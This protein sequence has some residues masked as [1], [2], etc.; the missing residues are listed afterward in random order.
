[1][2]STSNSSTNETNIDAIVITLV[3]LMG[4]LVL[5]P[6]Y[7]KNKTAIE[8]KIKR[9]INKKSH[10]VVI[11]TYGPSVAG[12]PFY[13]AHIA[14][15]IKF[16]LDPINKVNEVIIVG[17]YTVDQH[18]SQSQAVLNYI[19]DK[20]P[21]FNS[22][23]IPVTLDECGITTWQNIKNTKVLMDKNSIKAQKI[24][25]FAESSRE[26]KI[27]FF[28]NSTFHWDSSAII[29]KQ[30]VLKEIEPLVAAS[31]DAQLRAFTSQNSEWARFV[32]V[33]DTYLV[34]KDMRIMTV[35][36]GLP[37]QFVDE[38]YAK[39]FQEIKEF[40]D[41]TYASKTIRAKLDAWSAT[42]GF[43]VAENLVKKGCIEYKQFLTK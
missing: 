35:S 2:D 42:A 1:M 9:L 34:D 21:E 33:K 16:V 10:V 41:S 25:I 14:K 43:N 19:K 11:S 23:R 40:Y 31:Q 5:I 30:K 17:G 4:L 32:G 13:E 8:T 27:A 24:T 37:Q 7:K 15:A 12:S 6:V 3:V 18:I 28:A 20:Y 36:S 22:A 39:I 29:D 38:E 26:K